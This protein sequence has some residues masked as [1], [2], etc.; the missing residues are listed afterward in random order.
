MLLPVRPAEMVEYRT[1][2]FGLCGRFGSFDPGETYRHLQTG[3]DFE[4]IA[5]IRRN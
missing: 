1:V 5:R 3:T 4:E 2:K